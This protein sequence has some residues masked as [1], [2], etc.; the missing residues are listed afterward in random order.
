MDIKLFDKWW[1]QLSKGIFFSFAGI[2]ILGLGPYEYL[3]N[4]LFAGIFLMIFG[5]LDIFTSLS[6][7][8]LNYAWQ[9][10]LAEGLQYLFFGLIII[11]KTGITF[12]YL[13]LFIGLLAMFT[14]ILHFSASINYRNSGILR[15]PAATFNG[16]VSAAFSVVIIFYPASDYETASKIISLYVISEGFL[17]ALNSML[18]EQVSCDYS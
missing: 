8:E 4:P 1:L 9:W 6:N 14:G 13:Q 12:E 16:I 3:E 18:L 11:M 17:V 7:R 5:T 2:L 10:L 15:W